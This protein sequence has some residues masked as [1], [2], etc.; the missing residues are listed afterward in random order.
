MRRRR[1]RR[2]LI[3][4]LLLLCRLL[5][6][7][8]CCCFL[9]RHVISTPLRCKN[10]EQ[11]VRGISEFDRGVKFSLQ[12]SFGRTERGSCLGHLKSVG[13]GLGDSDLLP[14]PWILGSATAV[15]ASKSA[16]EW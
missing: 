13:D 3:K 4:L 9:R 10:V 7:L 2:P 12:K 11:C 8:L 6:G 14:L 16:G 1:G 15:L 5:D